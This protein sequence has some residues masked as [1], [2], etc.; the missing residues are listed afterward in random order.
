MSNLRETYKWIDEYD[1][2]QLTPPPTTV[3]FIEL[4][5]D[6]EVKAL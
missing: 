6:G 5:F 3:H 1:D 2:K 4:V